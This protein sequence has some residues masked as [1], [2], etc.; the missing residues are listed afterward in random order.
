MAN[1]KRR[2]G[3]EERKERD[4]GG[5]KWGRREER[6]KRRPSMRME[7]GFRKIGEPKK[8]RGK[9]ACLELMKKGF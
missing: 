4:E 1:E 9:E 6:R 5:E 2:G 3:G 7:V 8:K